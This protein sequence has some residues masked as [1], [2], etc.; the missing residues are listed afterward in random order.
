M[1]R[2][3]GPGDIAAMTALYTRC[4]GDSSAF[5]DAVFRHVLPMGDAL[6]DEDP[7]GA[8]AA[9]ALVPQLPVSTG[10]TAGYVYA[11]CTRPESRGHG[12]MKRLLNAVHQ[13]SDARG[14]AFTLLIPATPLLAGTYTHFQYAPV[15]YLRESTVLAHAFP[16]V[17]PTLRRATP[18][19]YPCINRLWRTS[20]GQ[21]P[22]ICRSADMYCTLDA[23]YGNAG[24][25]FYLCR[26]GGYVFLDAENELTV[27]EAV[28]PNGGDLSL[29]LRAVASHFGRSSIRC[30]LPADT[31]KPFVY[32]RGRCPSP[33]RFNLLFD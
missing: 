22:S 19:D 17:C 18:A 32:A 29:L 27:R 21:R 1:I 30:R 25:G 7:H 14:D 9:M 6:V 15:G 28:V 10:E 26:C 33:T 31:G 24:G 4:F 8:L 23:L 16:T 20:A 11:L 2:P 5:T 12:C 13:F 3:A